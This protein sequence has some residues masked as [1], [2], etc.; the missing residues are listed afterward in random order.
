MSQIFDLWLQLLSIFEFR[1][2]K[3]FEIGRL[4]LISFNPHDFAIRKRG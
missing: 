1:R 3:K 2:I 4:V